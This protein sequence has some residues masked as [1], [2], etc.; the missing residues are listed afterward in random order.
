MRKVAV[1]LSVSVLL[2]MSL[3][4]AIQEAGQLNTEQV[5]MRASND[6]PD[7]LHLVDDSMFAETVN[8]MDLSL[9]HI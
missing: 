7:P 1:I 9:I 6:V 5:E 4:S 3:S 2:L 8:G